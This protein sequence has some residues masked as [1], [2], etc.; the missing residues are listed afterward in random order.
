[1]LVS[2]LVTMVRRQDLGQQLSQIKD[3]MQ[4]RKLAMNCTNQFFLVPLAGS[5]PLRQARIV[6][7]RLG[8]RPASRWAD[9]PSWGHTCQRL[10]AIEA[11]LTE[12]GDW[13]VARHL[14]VLP[15]AEVNTDE[16]TPCCN[17]GRREERTRTLT[18]VVDIPPA[19]TGVDESTSVN[20]NRGPVDLPSAAPTIWQRCSKRSR[21]EKAKPG[22]R[23]GGGQIRGASHS[24]QPQ[25]SGSWRAFATGEA[26]GVP[27]GW[28]NPW[29]VEQATLG[30]REKASM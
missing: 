10:R 29:R 16:R 6:H 20:K 25:D 27:Q 8:G 28:G 1:M 15:D 4:A 23:K 7:A 21:K 17:D 19:K 18:G 9:S 26:F 12:G 3:A 24:R 13:T 22:R 11:S 2:T 5:T 30:E 14:E